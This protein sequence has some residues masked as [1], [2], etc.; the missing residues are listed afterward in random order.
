M[1]DNASV[2]EVN[3]SPCSHAAR[4][5]TYYAIN[6]GTGKKDAYLSAFCCTTKQKCG[7]EGACIDL[8]EARKE[9]S[10]DAL[11]VIVV[12]MVLVLVLCAA[13]GLMK[14]YRY[15][16]AKQLEHE[17]GQ[18]SKPYFKKGAGSA[19]PVPEEPVGRPVNLQMA[20]EE[21]SGAISYDD[22]GVH[23]EPEGSEMVVLP[24]EHDV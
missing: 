21:R 3:P 4:C 23:R 18:R 8:H 5:C 16:R 11:T 22:I 1:S 17:F 9:L 13:A 10:H 6:M 15:R 24:A 19:I 2:C 14:W 20:P 12:M 7:D